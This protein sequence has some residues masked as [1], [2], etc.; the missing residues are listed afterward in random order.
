[1]ARMGNFAKTQNGN[2]G[3]VRLHCNDDNAEKRELLQTEANLPNTLSQLK[4]SSCMMKTMGLWLLCESS[5]FC[6]L[7]INHLQLD[8]RALFT[9]YKSCRLIYRFEVQTKIIQHL[10]IL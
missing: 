9:D 1:M 5:C 6:L 10:K 4:E 8:V 2:N 3:L 7:C